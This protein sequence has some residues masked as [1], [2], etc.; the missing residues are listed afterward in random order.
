[1]TAYEFKSIGSATSVD[2][3]VIS[4]RLTF[5]NDTDV[6]FIDSNIDVMRMY[7]WSEADKTFN[8]IGS[9]LSLGPVGIGDIEHLNGDEFVYFDNTWEHVAL[10][11]WNSF[12]SAF[13]YVAGL[14]I[15]GASNICIGRMSTS[16]FAVTTLSDTFSRQSIRAMRWNGVAI[17]QIAVTSLTIGIWVMCALDGYDVAVLDSSADKLRTL[18]WNGSAWS[19]VGSDLSVS[20]AN[21]VITELSTSR[22]LVASSGTDRFQI[23]DWDGS[24]WSEFLNQSAVIGLNPGIAARN[25]TE[26][27]Y[28]DADS[29]SLGMLKL[30]TLETLG[31]ASGVITVADYPVT[32]W[33]SAKYSNYNPSEHGVMMCVPGSLQMRVADS[34]NSFDGSPMTAYLERKALPLGL[35]NR[36]GSIGVDYTKYEKYIHE[37]RLDVEGTAGGVL[38]IKVGTRRLPDDSTT[39]STEQD[40]IIGTTKKLDFRATGVI[41][42]LHIESDSDIE[43]SLFSYDIEYEI[44]GLA[45]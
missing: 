37:V 9:E 2:G 32:V 17:S 3:N 15:S 24:N 10:F 14:T 26:V 8:R 42:D 22:V 25:S 45:R 38:K 19:Q 1:M 27:A 5:R 33:V 41:T 29:D 30:V 35:A 31:P 4:P 40:W 36:D 7:R 6:V 18:R 20:G 12:N 34:G 13:S 39:W 11:R 21:Q 28:I 44:D 23:F 16:E 43:W